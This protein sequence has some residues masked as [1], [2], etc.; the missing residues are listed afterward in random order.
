MPLR[1]RGAC[2]VVGVVGVVRALV[3]AARTGRRGGLLSAR[4]PSVG[5][6]GC[7]EPRARRPRGPSVG[8]AVRV[9]GGRLR[10]SWGA[11]AVGHVGAATALTRG[12]SGS[13]WPRLG[14]EL[15]A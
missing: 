11:R 13:S 10:S 6:A 9:T 3:V 1:C 14:F 7:E 2:G 8:R 15:G 12:G 5:R 4:W